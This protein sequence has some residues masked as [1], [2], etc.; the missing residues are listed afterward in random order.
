MKLRPISFTSPRS[1]AKIV[2]FVAVTTCGTHTSQPFLPDALGPV[3]PMSNGVDL[4]YRGV[5]AHF[6]NR[7]IAIAT[8]R[9]RPSGTDLR[10]GPFDCPPP[11]RIRFMHI[12]EASERRERIATLL[13]DFARA[14][15]RV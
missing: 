5:A 14:A 10:P 9:V 13:I 8:S 2:F 3:R 1:S 4:S 11:N 12:G 15:R 6:G 7:S